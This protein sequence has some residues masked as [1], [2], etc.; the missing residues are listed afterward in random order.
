M[1][2]TTSRIH[3]DLLPPEL[4]T[5]DLDDPDPSHIPSNAQVHLLYLPVLEEN[6]APHAREDG[7]GKR[8]LCEELPRNEACYCGEGQ[9]YDVS[10][11]KG[12]VK[13]DLGTD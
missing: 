6:G 4:R 3:H 12:E 9:E 5:R 10:L 7:V 2:G 8:V 11:D 1:Y 13:G